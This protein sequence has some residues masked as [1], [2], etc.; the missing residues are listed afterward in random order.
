VAGHYVRRLFFDILR[1][2]VVTRPTLEGDKARAVSEVLSG[3]SVGKVIYS[4]DLSSATDR[5]HQ[6]A[7]VAILSTILQGWE[8]AEYPICD[9]LALRLL[10][11]HDLYV[12]GA[13]YNYN[14]RGILMGSPVSWPMLNIANFFCFALSLGGSVKGRPFGYVR[15]R[16]RE[17]ERCAR[18][19]GDDLL[20]VIPR[21]VV[22]IYEKTLG[23][24]GFEPSIPKSFV[25]SNG[26]VF[27]E[28][29]FRAKKKAVEVLDLFPPLT[30]RNRVV[31][32]HVF[33]GY[34][35]LGDIPAKLFTPRGGNGRI[36]VIKLGP[37]LT[38]HLEH[39]PSNFLPEVLRSV[40]RL[41]GKVMPGLVRE[42]YK[43]GID[44]GAPR[45]LG[46]LELPWVKLST[47]SHKIA[48]ILAAPNLISKAFAQGDANLLLTSDLSR[49]YTTTAHHPATEM[50]TEFALADCPLTRGDHKVVGYEKPREG[51]LDIPTIVKSEDWVPLVRESIGGHTYGLCAMGIFPFVSKVKTP[52]DIPLKRIG[53]LLRTARKRIIE[54]YPS[55]KPSSDVYR[56]LQKYKENISLLKSGPYSP[57]QL[58]RYELGVRSSAERCN[59]VAH[60]GNH[61]NRVRLQRVLSADEHLAGFIP[62]SYRR[63]PS[64]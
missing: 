5:C 44:P 60:P 48:S 9:A 57:S 31:Y 12:G 2:W 61:V 38:A 22:E 3:S 45:A 59:H 7:L 20:A 30:N 26:G 53:A 1:R 55:A 46:G 42:A 64:C 4:S 43:F 51:F 19:C 52:D 54:V 49:P 33:D 36:P 63:N 56:S 13:C 58:I 62:A 24:I 15:D 23:S 18:I 41:M 27:A 34:T 17:A 16:I 47:M 25:S 14:N 50:A 28:F 8:I 39:V 32:N 21:P 37:A 10:G 35:T 11:Q 40:K 6:D 29:T